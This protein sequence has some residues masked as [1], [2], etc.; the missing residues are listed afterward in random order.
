M[1]RAAAVSL[2]LAL[3]AG[4]NVSWVCTVLCDRTPA[5]SDCHHEQPAASVTAPAD[6]CCE[7]G[8]PDAA[9]F[10]PRDVRQSGVSL[11]SDHS[12]PVS[13]STIGNPLTEARRGTGQ[14]PVSAQDR[15]PLSAA[16]RL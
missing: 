11:D 5:T 7:I 13:R 8:A 4:P 6:N 10:V 2:V 14:S 15:H 3:A 1:F 16:L 12:S 9:R